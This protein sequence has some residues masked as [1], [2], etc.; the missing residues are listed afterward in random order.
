MSNH[1][2][3]IIVLTG[4]IGSGKS[5][6]A[7]LFKQLGADVIDAD[8]ISKEIVQPK[9]KTLNLIH[10]HFGDVILNQ[11]GSLN[12]PRLQQIIF[13]DPAAKR[14]LENYYIP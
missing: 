11:D 7:Q 8:D 10:E 6:V 14:W 3:L 12:R 4:G 9:S 2:K 13:N 1:K 5:T